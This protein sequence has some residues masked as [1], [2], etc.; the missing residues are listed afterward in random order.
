MKRE[1][2]VFLTSLMFYTR[3]PCGRWVRHEGGL[4]NEATRYLPLVGWIV[5]GV[6]AAVFWTGT[7]LLGAPLGLLL[8]MAAGVL[9]TGAFHEDGFADFCDG[10]GGGWTKEKILEIMKDSR[11]G[12]YG[13]AGLVLLLLAKFLA[14]QQLLEGVTADPA[15]VFLLFM[16]AHAASRFTAATFIFTHAYIR[17]AGDSKVKPVAHKTHP[18]TLYL[19]LVFALLP[20]AA[21]AAYTGKPV[22]FAVAIPLFLLHHFLGRYFTKWIGGYTGDCLGAAQQLAEIVIYLTCI[23]VWKFT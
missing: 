12:S 2:Q 20:L 15:F 22:L 4:L 3:I 14:L 21:L 9:V 6:S 11:T 23:V 8:S 19:S 7:Y 1:L 17:P 13:V 10:F 16:T 5:G 18:A